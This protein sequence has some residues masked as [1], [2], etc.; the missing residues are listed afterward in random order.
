MQWCSALRCAIAIAL[1]ATVFG[2]I[3]SADIVPESTLVQKMPMHEVVGEDKYTTKRQQ[4]RKIELG[5]QAQHQATKK[6][7]VVE[8]PPEEKAA[9]QAV[10]EDI[11]LPLKAA[12]SKQVH[13]PKFHAL[14]A[15]KHSK[16]VKKKVKPSIDD[17]RRWQP[18]LSR[19]SKRWKS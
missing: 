19:R 14:V 16:R 17:L 12:H 3:E 11:P 8:L 5:W 6:V 1:I 7:S 10:K 4:M 2:S 18:R 15:P 9:L 13:D